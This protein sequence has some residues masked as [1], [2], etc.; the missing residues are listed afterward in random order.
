MN[1]THA[2][3]KTLPDMDVFAAAALASTTAREKG[4]LDRPRDIPEVFALFHSELSEALEA[5][6]GGASLQGVHIE[7]GKPEG[8]PPELADFVIRVLEW[9]ESECYPD[10]L[11]GIADGIVFKERD[12][13]VVPFPTLITELHAGVS[14]AYSHS[15]GDRWDD[16]MRFLSIAVLRVFWYCHRT[17]INLRG[18]IEQKQAYNATRPQRHGGKVI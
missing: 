10:V 9:S 11:M 4:W 3:T 17:D 6:R 16:M 7:N 13:E 1:E 12:M 14:A 18:A 15:E 5:F 2:H 8:I